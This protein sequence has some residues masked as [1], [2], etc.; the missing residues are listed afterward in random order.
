MTQLRVEILESFKGETVLLVAVDGD[1]LNR[2]IEALLAAVQ[3]GFETMQLP[4]AALAHTFSVEGDGADVELSPTGVAWRC[5][6]PKFI[7]LLEKLKAM[8]TLGKPCHHYIDISR[9][10]KMLVL[11]RDEYF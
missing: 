6:R 1:G 3:L 8:K 2:L 11:S 9:P 10:V 7:E 4:D 5:S